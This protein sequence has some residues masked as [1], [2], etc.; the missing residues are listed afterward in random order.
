MK[1]I[2][3]LII[4]SLSCILIQAQNKDISGN[5]YNESGFCL[6]IK[7]DSFKLIVREASPVTRSSEVWAEGV[8]SQINESLIELNTINTPWERVQK[9]IKI[10]QRRENKENDIYLKFTIPY[11]KTDLR[12]YL[13]TDK[14]GKSEFVYSKT[15]TG[16]KIPRTEK[17]SF[18]IV[19]EYLLPHNNGRFYGIIGYDSIMEYP[20]ENGT[21]Y[22]EFNIPTIDDSF[23]E[24][25]YI[26]GDYARTIN[27][28]IIWKGSIYKKQ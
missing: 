9:D 13:Y 14:F 2:I 20:I 24:K 6:Q 28:S 16:I 1:K 4:T 12:I 10:I 26:E 7:K 11:N 8:I 17:I 19:P 22:I 23:F 27:D 21:N 25:Y 3:L 18:Y 15:N 5:Y